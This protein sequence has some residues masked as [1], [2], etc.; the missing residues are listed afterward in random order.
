MRD[1]FTVAA[2]GGSPAF[3]LATPA[4]CGHTM[5]LCVCVGGLGAAPYTTLGVCARARFCRMLSARWDGK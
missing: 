3:S 2:A 5:A 4:Q 1:P